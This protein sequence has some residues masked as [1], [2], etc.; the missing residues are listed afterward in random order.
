M[1]LRRTISLGCAGLLVAASARA[2]VALVLYRTPLAGSQYY[3]L[4]QSWSELRVGDRVQLVRDPGN[5]HDAN[6][7]RVEW[8]GRP[9]GHLPRAHNQPIAEAMDAGRRI[10]ARI[11]SL[12]PHPDPWQRVVLEVFVDL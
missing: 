1:R 6:A 3:A 12:R 5:R 4:E 2:G 8:R 10:G 11:I 7:V 9:L